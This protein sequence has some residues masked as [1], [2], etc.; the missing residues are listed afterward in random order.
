[1]NK[2]K[3][4]Q[5][6]ILGKIYNLIQD[7]SISESERTFLVKSKNEIEKGGLF[8]SHMVTLRNRLLPLVV[9][10][11]ISPEVLDFYKLIRA[12][13]KIG[14]GAGDSLFFGANED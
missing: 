9:S 11:K 12:D 4:N 10:K 1:M 3:N 14:I 13:R 5:E 2:L 6:I 7:P 8:E